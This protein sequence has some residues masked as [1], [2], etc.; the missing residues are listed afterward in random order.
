ME[1][2]HLSISQQSNDVLSFAAQ[3]NIEFHDSELNE[4]RVS[5][6]KTKDKEFHKSSM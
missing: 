5:L 1:Q 6:L 4:T 2:P 3:A